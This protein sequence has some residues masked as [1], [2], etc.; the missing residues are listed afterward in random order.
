MNTSPALAA[1]NYWLE[2]SAFAAQ[3]VLPIN[4]L[5]FMTKHSAPEFYNPTA[6]PSGVLVTVRRR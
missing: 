5:L 2:Q 1:R 3:L 4:D 6:T